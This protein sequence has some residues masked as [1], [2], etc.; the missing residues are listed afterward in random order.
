[1]LCSLVCIFSR[2]GTSYRFFIFF[3]LCCNPQV[4]D[5][6]K[7]SSQ[8]WKNLSADEREKWDDVARKDKERYMNEKAS[9]TG[10]WQV[11]WKR[12][13]KVRNRDF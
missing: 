7:R 1:M 13:K 6:S 11:P 8:M 12:S 9:Y 5:V 3:V 10:P 4:G 2:F